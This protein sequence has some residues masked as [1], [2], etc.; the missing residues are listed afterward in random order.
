MTYMDQVIN[1]GLRIGPAPFS[2]RFCTKDWK[3]SGDDLVIP[4]GTKVYI[5]I[6]GL[7]YDEDYFEDPCKFD[8]ERFNSENKAKIPAGAFQ[9]FGSGPRMCLGYN[10]FK[11]ETKI[12]L[13]HLLRNFSLKK[14]GEMPEKMEWDINTFVGVKGGV[15]I[16]LVKRT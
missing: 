8:P 2:N 12:M 15:K 11:L 6:G 1:E 9:P 3:I 10:M 16:S 7:C 13:V 14:H 4:K 5:P